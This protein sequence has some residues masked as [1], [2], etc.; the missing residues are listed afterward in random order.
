MEIFLRELQPGYAHFPIY[1]NWFGVFLT[2]N[3]CSLFLFLFN[4]QGVS[5]LK[6][7]CDILVFFIN[8]QKLILTF[9]FIEIGLVCFSQEIYT[10][11]F[12]FPSLPPLVFLSLVFSVCS[13]DYGCVWQG[14]K[15]LT[16]NC[17]F[18]VSST[19]NFIKSVQLF[20]II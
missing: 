10:I 6:E 4:V 19:I 12:L 3:I 9:Q 13:V 8:L 1:R 18:S 20:I 17:I 15:T 16:F 5:L 7:Y 11:T 14:I 2:G